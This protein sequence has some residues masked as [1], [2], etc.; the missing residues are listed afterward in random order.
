M[1]KTTLKLERKEVVKRLFDLNG[2]LVEEVIETYTEEE[3]KEIKHKI[4]FKL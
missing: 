4:G 2:R 1:K 3:K